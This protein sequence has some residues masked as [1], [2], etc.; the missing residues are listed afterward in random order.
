MPFEDRVDDAAQR[1]GPLAVDDPDL[2]EPTR[3]NLLQPVGHQLLHVAGVKG[4]EVERILDGDL[5]HVLMMPAMSEKAIAHVEKSFPRHIESL[6]ALAKI[7]SVSADPGATGELKRSA[8][9]VRAAMAE[10]GLKN[11]AV[12]D[13][14]G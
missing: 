10:A 11:T 14:A 12:L 9:A 5:D 4:V 3:S 2:G 1:A 8:E 6:K 13:L 7:P